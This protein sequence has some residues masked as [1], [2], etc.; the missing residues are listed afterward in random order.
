ML[1]ILT[2]ISF[3]NI[4]YLLAVHIYKWKHVADLETHQNLC[5]RTQTFRCHESSWGY[6]RAVGS[7]SWQRVSFGLRG[8][9]VSAMLDKTLCKLSW[10]YKMELV[11]ICP[12]SRLTSNN[13]CRPLSQQNFMNV[14]F[15]IALSF[16]GFKEDG[17]ICVNCIK[18][19]AFAQGILEILRQKSGYFEFCNKVCASRILHPISMCLC[20]LIKTVWVPLGFSGLP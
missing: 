6:I 19:E 13:F 4:S 10:F 12:E 1:A 16:L 8:K 20:Q 2:N 11:F 14:V 5:A 7:E 17:M 9:V 15:K 3:T 18:L